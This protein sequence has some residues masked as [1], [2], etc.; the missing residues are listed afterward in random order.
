MREFVGG[1]LFDERGRVL[2]VK[3]ASADPDMGG[4]W[5]LPA[6]GVD[7]AESDA[8]ALTR[9]FVEETGLRVEVGERV[10]SVERS[11]WRVNV[12]LTSAVGMTPGADTDRDVEGSDWFALDGLPE[13]MVLEARIAV[14]R[15]VIGTGIDIS[16][17]ALTDAIDGLFAALF[18]SYIRPFLRRLAD[19][20]HGDIVI[21][22][23]LNTPDRRFKSAVPFL[24]SD[25]SAEAGF[26]AVIAEALFSLWTILD[27]ACDDRSTR[28]GVPTAIEHFGRGPVVAFLFGA[29]EWFSMALRGRAGDAY[30]EQITEALLGCANAQYARFRGA[31]HAI[32]DYLTAAAERVRFLGT[33]WAA[34]LAAI[35]RPR[36]AATL[37][38]LHR[39]TA[40]FGQLLNDYFDLTR[41][42]GLRD[43]RARIRSAY[44]IKLEEIASAE[45]RARLRELWS[46]PER[47]APTAE[48]REIAA[49]YALDERLRAELHQRLHTLISSVEEL[50]LSE[51]HRAV[52]V[53]WL[54]L[55]LRD[56]LPR[57]ADDSFSANLERFLH[58]FEEICK[59]IP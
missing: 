7:P 51:P 54:E 11:S 36:E 10:T 52:L 58:G 9:E 17:A 49:R 46:F 6:G 32:D 41:P 16:A 22:A 56:T 25:L 48:F 33:A 15:Y 55:S 47:A 1:L 39:E 53:G 5:S 45:D 3:R 59:F 37:C 20:E 13:N 21:W 30:A 38:A 57:T 26:Y 8:Q 18:H 29:V 4:L 12:Y 40:R 23:V 28:Y 42:G 44:V 2:L 27:D 19:V 24:L 31:G 43:V 50:P 35:G 34:G 14:V